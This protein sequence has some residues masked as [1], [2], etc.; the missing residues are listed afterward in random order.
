MLPKYKKSIAL[1]IR[2][3]VALENCWDLIKMGE[4]DSGAL[5]LLKYQ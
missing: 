1:L 2:R 5:L 3:S 4:N